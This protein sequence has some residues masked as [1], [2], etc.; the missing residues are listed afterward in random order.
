MQDTKICAHPQLKWT[1]QHLVKKGI[2]LCSAP[3]WSMH[4]SWITGIEALDAY[5]RWVSEVV[6]PIVF[7]WIEEHKPDVYKEIP[8][9]LKDDV[10]VVIASAFEIVKT[11]PSYL[12]GIRRAEEF[13]EARVK[14]AVDLNAI[15][16][17]WTDITRKIKEDTKRIFDDN[18]GFLKD[19][20]RRSENGDD[21]A[22]GI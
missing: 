12:N 2:G 13:D 10:G 22:E 15:N 18:Q 21:N 7:Q 9:A 20:I 14:G 8:E 3:D 19:T 6:I 4:P 1:T 16:P 5:N 11:M 17:V